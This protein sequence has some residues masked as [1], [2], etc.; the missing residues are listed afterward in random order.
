MK[1]GNALSQNE[2]IIRN[3]IDKTLFAIID[4]SLQQWHDWYVKTS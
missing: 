2:N 4:H 1:I 3:K